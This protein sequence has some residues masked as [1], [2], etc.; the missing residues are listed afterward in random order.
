MTT[1]PPLFVVP[2]PA[3]LELKSGS[4]ADPPTPYTPN[5]VSTS[6]VHKQIEMEAPPP[7]PSERTESEMK[8]QPGDRESGGEQGLPGV[9][10]EERVEAV[11]DHASEGTPQTEMIVAP[12]NVLPPSPPLTEIEEQEA[13]N[14]NHAPDSQ[15]PPPSPRIA[16]ED[17]TVWRSSINGS[18]QE[19]DL[20]EETPIDETG[21]HLGA[22]LQH[23]GPSQNRLSVPSARHEPVHPL[24]INSKSQP[25]SPPPWEL[26]EPPESNNNHLTPVDET[27]PGG[28]ST[29][30]P[31]FMYVTP[32]LHILPD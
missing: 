3:N 2:P 7:L 27:F 29:S 23:G 32:K 6:S 9:V 22:S 4:P 1:S 31:K 11:Q 5:S 14:G 19:D 21:V 20:G 24:S 8:L 28:V 25:P 26:I 18:Y 13:P 12:P 16:E 10:H 15:N 17:I 30:M